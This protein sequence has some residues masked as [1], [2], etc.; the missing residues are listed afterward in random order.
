[1]S[2]YSGNIEGVLALGISIVSAG[3]LV[4]PS[5]GLESSLAT[6]AG[7]LAGA[8]I[9]GVAFVHKKYLLVHL[10]LFFLLLFGW[11]SSPLW[12][13][14]LPT[15]LVAP[16][17]S[18]LLIVLLVPPLRKTLSWF[19]RGRLNGNTLLFAVL[20]VVLSLPA[21]LLWALYS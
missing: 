16:F 12:P 20:I 9:L 19:K 8:L 15:G 3:M 7:L 6:A 5:A 13:S 18:Y 2:K 4:L 10:C 11:K 21:L 17:L 14:D 1:M